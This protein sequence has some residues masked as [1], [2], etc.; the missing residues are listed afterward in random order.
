MAGSQSLPGNIAAAVKYERSLLAHGFVTD[1][2]FYKVPSGQSNAV[3]GTLLK[4][5][6]KTETTLYSLPPAT[7]LSRFMYQSA[8]LMGDPIPATAYILWPYQP[9]TLP[10]G[11]YPVVVWAHGTSGCHEN[12]APSNAKT[13][14]QHWMAP[15]PLALHGY[16][17]VA[18]DYAGLG[19]GRTADGK[20]IIHQYA[21]NPA[22]AHDVVFAVEAAQKAFAKLSSKF[23]VMG[24]SQGGGA[25]WAVAERQ[26]REPVNGY[27]GAI[28]ISPVTNFLDLDATNNPR[29][30]LIAMYATRTMEQL[31]PDFRA[32]DFFTEKGWERFKIEHQI[33]IYIPA[34]VE[35]LTGF[36]VLKDGWQDDP[37]LRRFADLT[38]AGGRKIAGP[39]FVIQGGADADMQPEITTSAVEKTITAFPDSQIQ[40]ALL[41]GLGHDPTMYGSQQLWLN[42]IEERFQGAEIKAGLERIKAVEPAWPVDSYQSNATW[43]IKTATEP[44]EII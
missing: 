8:N 16:V 3:P 42:W 31:Y 26:A 7:A 37:F 36:Q 29:I 40:Y 21:A 27:L 25:A 35:L 38:A 32:Q 39:L 10:D 23:V 15:Y 4:V 43:V 9:R 44:Y 22:Q 14:S 28:P 17:T 20:D 34:L 19:V 6:Q 33:G 24:H 1:D 30:P 13:L 2:Q 18:P 41:P 12:A 5:E 11:Q